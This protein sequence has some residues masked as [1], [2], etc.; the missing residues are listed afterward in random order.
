MRESCNESWHLYFKSSPVFLLRVSSVPTLSFRTPQCQRARAGGGRC[1]AE[2]VSTSSVGSTS[3]HCWRA[4]PQREGAISCPLLPPSRPAWGGSS[5]PSVSVGCT[6]SEQ[7]SGDGAVLS[8][9][10][11]LLSVHSFITGTAAHGGH[12]TPA[13]PD[14]PAALLAREEFLSRQVSTPG[15]AAPLAATAGSQ[16]F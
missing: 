7:G 1:L 9:C 14:L 11:S 10:P 13:A 15:L 6:P 12:M 2:R 4:S 5:H 3:R 8:V 16:S